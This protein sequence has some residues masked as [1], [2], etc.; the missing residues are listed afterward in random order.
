MSN[1]KHMLIAII[2]A[3]AMFAAIL[4]SIGCFENVSRIIN[5]NNS[6]AFFS[7][8]LMVF[9]LV[10]VPLVN[11]FAVGKDRNIIKRKVTVVSLLI[12]IGLSITFIISMLMGIIAVNDPLDVAAAGI[13]M[14]WYTICIIAVAVFYFFQSRFQK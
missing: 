2:N 8:L 1:T 6:V 5:A 3:V 7:L 13:C 9:P 14:A 11:R 4:I 10:F 12:Y